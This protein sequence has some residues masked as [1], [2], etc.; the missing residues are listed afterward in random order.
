MTT[1]SKVLLLLMA[2]ALALIAGV[3]TYTIVHFIQE[4]ITITEA[5]VLNSPVPYGDDVLIR[6][7][8]DRETLC[9]TDADIFILKQPEQILV[10]TERRPAGLMPLG[11]SSWTARLPTLGLETGK[12]VVRF[13]V[14][15]DCGDRLHTI[16]VPDLA[17]EVTA[18]DHT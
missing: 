3:N 2:V 15:N 16:K 14:H 9:K 1:L 10:F 11:T 13:F 6:Y 12:Y 7:T 17:F 5:K 4:P 8:A 18:S